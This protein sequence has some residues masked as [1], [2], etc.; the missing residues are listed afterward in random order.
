L[1]ATSPEAIRLRFFA[2]FQLSRTGA[3]HAHDYTRE[4]AFT[5]AAQARTANRK[6]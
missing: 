6:R 1:I 5:P 2:A 4:M 3:V